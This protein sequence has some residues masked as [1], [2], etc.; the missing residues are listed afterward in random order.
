MMKASPS[1]VSS[2]PAT[3]PISVERDSRLAIRMVKNTSSV[4]K[5]S[6]MNR[7]PNGFMPNIASP[8]PMSSLPT[9]GC[10]MYA[11]SSFM[12][13]RSPRRIMSL[14]PSTHCRSKPDCRS[15]QASLA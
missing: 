6:A 14:A 5:T 9:G 11:A 13:E 15:P 2:S 3:P 4:P 1:K 7:H 10:T 8:T 12:P